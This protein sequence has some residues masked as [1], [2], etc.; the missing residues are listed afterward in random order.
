MI[1]GALRNK[2]VREKW[3]CEVKRGGVMDWKMI[4]RGSKDRAKKK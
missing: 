3:D 1:R 4:I 2:N